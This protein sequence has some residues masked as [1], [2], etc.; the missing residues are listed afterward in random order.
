MGVTHFL[1]YKGNLMENAMLTR[2]AGIV[3][4]AGAMIYM[5]LDFGVMAFGLPD[6]VP[7]KASTAIN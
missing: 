2:I 1:K 6:L 7:G 3:L 5:G 4:I